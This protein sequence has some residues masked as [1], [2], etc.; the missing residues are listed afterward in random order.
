MHVIDNLSIFKT[1][2]GNEYLM[3]NLLNGVADIIDQDELEILKKWKNYPRSEPLDN[4]IEFYKALSKRE[5]IFDDEK[6]EKDYRAK[7]LKKLQEK[8][9]TEKNTLTDVTVVFSYTCNFACS[10]CF[11]ESVMQQKNP[12][13][14]VEMLDKIDEVI[15]HLQRLMFYGGE[16]FLESN[17]D[18]VSYIIKKYP[19][20]SYRAIT[21]GYNLDRYLDLLQSVKVDW[22]QITLDGK[23]DTHD[24][25][26]FLKG[27]RAGTYEKIMQN[28]DLMIR[29]QIPVKIRM[30][31][32]TSN[33]EECLALREELKSQYQNSDLLSFE[34]Q[35]LFQYDNNTR[36]EL[37]SILYDVE[38][39]KDNVIGNHKNMITGTL[40]SKRPFPLK[41]HNCF[42]ETSGRIMDNYG[43][44][45]SCLLAVGKSDSR[46]GTYYPNLQYFEKSLLHRNIQSTKKCSF[47]KFALLCGGG[48]G[49]LD[50]QNKRD[51]LPDCSAIN[52]SLY[53]YAKKLGYEL[54]GEVLLKVSGE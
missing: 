13:F 1:N 5:Y 19:D 53:Q 27:N 16:P 15:P 39:P 20:I 12:E 54:S 10:Y 49:L 30:N 36:V 31:I 33:L 41:Y 52:R 48:C 44:L 21:N 38:D 34:L 42:A 8:Y 26:R 43:N 2:V 18:K 37:E 7:I 50:E 25:R 23:R 46:I 24:K 3:M 47:C 40:D 4:E 32:S 6:T 51:F 35:P 29:H 9:Q 11:E 17:F 14:T 22:I 45:Y 28:I